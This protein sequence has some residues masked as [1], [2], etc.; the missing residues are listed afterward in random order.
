MERVRALINKLQEQLDQQADTH[1]LLVT[2][3][4][5]QAEL[6]GA[7]KPDASRSGSTKV[8]VVMPANSRRQAES[9]APSYARTAK[10]GGT[11]SRWKPASLNTR[12][13]SPP[14]HRQTGFIT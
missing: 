5:L 13:L 4:L 11:Q 9:I 7:S 12:Y 6:Q 14:R 1:S 3:Q 8:A 2:V 10:N